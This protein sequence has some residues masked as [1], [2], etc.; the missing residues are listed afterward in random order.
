MS[1]LVTLPAPD[2]TKPAVLPNGSFDGVFN[3]AD[4]T[5]KCNFCKEIWRQAAVVSEPLKRPSKRS[6]DEALQSAHQ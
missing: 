5:L 1:V 4:S 2:F 3:L 6:T